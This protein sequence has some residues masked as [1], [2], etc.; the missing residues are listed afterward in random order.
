MRESN[1]NWNR[2]GLALLFKG[3]RPPQVWGGGGRGELGEEGS[4][5]ELFQL[6][7]EPQQKARGKELALGKC[8]WAEHCGRHNASG[9]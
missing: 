3:K 7:T 1:R 9:R 8:A 2:K 4:G 6:L 5:S